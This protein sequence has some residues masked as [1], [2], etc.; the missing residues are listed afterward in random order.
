MVR[1]LSFKKKM[2]IEAVNQSI[3]TLRTKVSHV[4]LKNFLICML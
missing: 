3:I 2:A 4:P 1:V